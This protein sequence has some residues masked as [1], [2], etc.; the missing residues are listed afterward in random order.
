MPGNARWIAWESLKKLKQ[1]GSVR[2]YV[3]EF[4]SLILDMKNMSDEDKFFNFISSL[5]PWAQTELRRQMVRDLPS[6]IAIADGLVDFRIASSLPRNLRKEK[7]QEK[8]A[9]LSVMAG[10]TRA[11][12]RNPN[13]EIHKKRKAWGASFMTVHTGQRIA[14]NATRSMPWLKRLKWNYQWPKQV[15]RI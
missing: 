7:I 14:Q 10:E 9:P 2:D 8:I 15:L 5:Q 3:K 13:R 11:S 4:S 12:Q 1:T 6:V